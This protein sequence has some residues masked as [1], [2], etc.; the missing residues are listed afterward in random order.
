M[1]RKRNRQDARRRQTESKGE[2]L[3][4]RGEGRE[5]KLLVQD[6]RTWG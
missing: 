2:W 5:K 4:R 1:R 6:E 3:T